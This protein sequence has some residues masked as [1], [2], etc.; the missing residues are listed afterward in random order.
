[1]TL[2]LDP[3][4]AEALAP[5]VAGLADVAPPPAGDVHGRRVVMNAMLANVDRLQPIADDVRIS[6]HELITADGARLLLRWYTTSST[7]DTSETDQ[8]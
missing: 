3:Q 6:D 4:I 1:M 5:F 2:D 8:A 7:D